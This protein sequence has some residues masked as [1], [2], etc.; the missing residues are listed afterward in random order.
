M[1]KTST[2]A[3]FEKWC[4]RHGMRPV[5]RITD[6]TIGGKPVGDILIADS[7]EMLSLSKYPPT[8]GNEH[9]MIYFYR[10]GF[11]VDRPGDKTWIASFNDY[12]PDAFI[13]YDGESRKAKRI[14][15]AVRYA[16][17]TLEQTHKAGLYDGD[18]R[19]TKFN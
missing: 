5:Q 16:A 10:T 14:E 13:E 2:P 19:R 3:F 9:G 12:P 7:D 1:D 15:E 18:T 4:R 11:A 17:A 6:V 8:D